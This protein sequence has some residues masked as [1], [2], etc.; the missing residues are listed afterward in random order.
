MDVEPAAGLSLGS[1]SDAT[2]PRQEVMLGEGSRTTRIRPGR[3]L[4]QFW[5][6]GEMEPAFS[7]VTPEFLLRIVESY[8][9]FSRSTS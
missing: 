2:H 4:S 9:G 8:G 5:T 6:H 1:R 3:F 7:G